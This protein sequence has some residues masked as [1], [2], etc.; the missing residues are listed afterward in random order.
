MQIAETNNLVLRLPKVSD[1]AMVL[2]LFNQQDCLKF[3]GDRNIRSIADAENYITEK[4]LSHYKTYGFCLYVVCQKQLNTAVGVCGLIKREELDDV[5]IGFAILTNFQGK[6]YVS[7]A[8]MAVKK[9]AVDTLGL[10]RLVGITDQLNH[11]SSRVLEKIGMTFEKHIK[12][13]N[14]DKEVKLYGLNV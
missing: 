14:D 3:I 2:G 6:G 11:G 8:A 4:F 13:N 12:L 10:K 5:D 1:A 7:E 9:H